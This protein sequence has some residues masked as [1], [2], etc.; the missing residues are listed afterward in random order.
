MDRDICFEYV[1]FSYENQKPVLNDVSFTIPA[2]KTFAILGGTGSGKTTLM[3]LLNRLYDL[4]EGGGRITIGGVNINQISRAHLRKMC[5]SFCRSHSCFPE[6]YGKI[7]AL[8]ARK[9][10]ASG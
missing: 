10:T 2:G 6:R 9:R 7:S 3:H 1:T 8:P 5:P 4:E